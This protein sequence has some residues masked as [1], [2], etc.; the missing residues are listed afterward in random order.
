MRILGMISGTSVD[1]I[2]VA[3]ADMY[4]V[5]DTLT[6]TT[7]GYLELPWPAAVR[8]RLLAMRRT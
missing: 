8:E 2:D 4:Q 1:A 6:L 3:L 5:D 7:L